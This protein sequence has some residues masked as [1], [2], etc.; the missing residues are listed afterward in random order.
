[1]TEPGVGPAQQALDAVIMTA[2][3]VHGSVR[4]GQDAAADVLQRWAGRLTGTLFTTLSRGIGPVLS[5]RTWA[6]C[7]LETADVLLA[8]QRR[9]VERLLVAQQRCLAQLTGSGTALAA[10][11]WDAAAPHRNPDRTAP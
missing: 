3:A 4:D 10:A 6:G 2:D 7:G 9:S 11:Y 1:M 8:A 5:G